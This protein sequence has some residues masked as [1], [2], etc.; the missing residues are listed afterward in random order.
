M[1]DLKANVSFL[2]LKNAALTAVKENPEG[3]RQ[4]DVAKHLGIPSKF[5]H[6]WITKGILDGL[7]EERQIKKVEINRRKLF[8][9]VAQ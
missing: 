9:P 8:M 2:N 4:A 1:P 3:I 7:V 6:N 5:D